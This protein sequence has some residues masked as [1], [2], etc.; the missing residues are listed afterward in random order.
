MA[1]LM[2]RLAAALSISVRSVMGQ[3]DRCSGRVWGEGGKGS[4]DWRGDSR[5]WIFFQSIV[6][7]CPDRG[8]SRV[9]WVHDRN[10]GNTLVLG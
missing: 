6:G 9:V 4:T 8:F 2:K 10:I 7:F 5:H 3:L 1:C